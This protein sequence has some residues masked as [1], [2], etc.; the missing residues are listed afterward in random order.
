MPRRFFHQ[1][2]VSA[3]KG[4]NVVELPINPNSKPCARANHQ[5]L[6]DKLAATKP[7]P[8]PKPPSNKGT[9]TPARSAQRPM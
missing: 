9:C 4:A 8:V 1:R 3:T 2:D 6:D 7:S 5:M